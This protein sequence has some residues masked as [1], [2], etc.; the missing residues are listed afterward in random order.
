MIQAS[1]GDCGAVCLAML[2]SAVRGRRLPVTELDGLRDLADRDGMSV[3][4]VRQAL[5]DHGLPAKAVRVGSA[6]D[7]RLLP[8]P[9]IALCH[10]QHYVVVESCSSRFVQICDPAIGKKRLSWEQFQQKF[11]G[12]AVAF[13]EPW[14]RVGAGPRAALAR[15][16][17]T[18]VP[19]RFAKVWPEGL[20]RL[21][22]AIIGLSIALELV[23]AG[24]ILLLRSL[25]GS[26]NVSLAGVL[27]ISLALIAVLQLFG[28]LGRG[29]MVARCN[30]DGES[31]MRQDCF[32]KII[33]FGFGYFQYRPPGYL[34]NLLGNTRQLN[35]A[36]FTTMVDGTMNFVTG[37]IALLVLLTINWL[38]GMTVGAMVALVCCGCVAARRRISSA[39][40]V[41]FEQRARLASMTDEIFRA[42]EGLCG[43]HA[44]AGIDQMWSSRSA[45][46]ARSGW[47][48]RMWN[49]AAAA[50]A[51]GSSQI[52]QVGVITVVL[53]QAHARLGA[54]DLV[55][56]V[57]FSSTAFIPL[58]EASRRTLRWGE[59][60]V[61]LSQLS[62]VWDRPAGRVAVADDSR[63]GF[64]TLSVSHL[65]VGFGAHPPLITDATFTVS[66]AERVG[67]SAP[68]GTGKTTL[69]RTLAGMIE[70]RAGTIQVDGTPMA[71]ATACGLRVAYVP[72]D[73]PL[74]EATI[75]ENLRVGALDATDDELW[76]A[77]G[78]AQIADDISGFPNRM[79]TLLSA[80]GAGLS[81][82]QR[83]RLAIARALLTRPWLLI[84]DEATSALDYPLEERLFNG[85]PPT[86]L[87]VVSHR[88][89]VM[90]AMDRVL[91]LS[92]GR[93]RDQE[94]GAA[95]WRPFG[96][97]P[98][99]KTEN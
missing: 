34:G 86:A 72:Q 39:A 52:L 94:L 67:I 91:V 84:L 44:Q 9:L 47:L 61:L 66:S 8:V 7:L 23:S 36:F 5:D 1:P 38:A 76:E 37:S 12:V 56:V 89:E 63:V 19:Y 2:V 73:V 79:D 82:G 93:L 53:I 77:C 11:T 35:D 42:I 27:L 70:P 10:T 54:G 3:R 75:A 20:R 17:T 60:D 97:Q 71:A 92:A 88:V 57:G 90:R 14:H 95:A 22:C 99:A 65:Q 40:K 62:D 58:L 55:A 96:L 26:S 49:Q 41:E 98:L 50:V 48:S 32:R 4:T 31:I 64:G 43:V 69:L 13:R 85:L 81:G 21:V 6:R 46:L 18:A 51:V 28:Q 15:L 87:L 25:L 59:I 24:T 83:Q 80:G 16:V 68:S 74:L 45:M 78:Q 30:N 29:L 33:T